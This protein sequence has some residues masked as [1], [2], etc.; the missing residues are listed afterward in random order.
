[1]NMPAFMIVPSL[2]CQ[3]SCKY[4][5][6][7][8]EGAVMD[9]RTAR[10]SIKF[11][12]N[13]ASETGTQDI[14][15][16]FHGGEPLL[17]PIE[18]WNAFFT[19]AKIQLNSYR[20]K[21]S[22]QSNLWRL[23]EEFIEL[24]KEN[25]VSIGTSLDGPKNLCDIN[26]GC[27]YYE[28][29]QASV[30]KANEAG[31]SVS[32]IA[33]ITKSTLSHAVEIAEYFRN[34][35]MPLALHGALAGMNEKDS[36]FALSPEEYSKMIL[37]LFPWYIENRKFMQI[38]TLDHFARAIARGDPG[39]CTFRDCFGMFACIS[40]DGGITSCQRLSGKPEFFMGSIFD[41]PSLAQLYESGPAKAQR[42]RE[43]AA[44]IKCSGCLFYQ[45]CKGGCYYNAVSSGDGVIDPLCEAYKDIFAFVQGK[46]MEEMRSEE[47]IQAVAEGIAGTY[48]HPLLRKGA[49]ISLS[50]KAH[51]ARIADN[52]RRILAVY[53]LGKT[54][55]AHEAALNLFSQRICG[56]IPV[57]EKLLRGIHQRLI[58]PG[59]RLN[60]CYVHVTLNCNLRCKHCYADAGTSEGQMDA[61]DFYRLAAEAEEAKF[62]QIVITGGE[63]LVHSQRDELIEI[64][65]MHKGKGTNLVLRTNLTG[66]LPDGAFA[67]LAAAFDQVVVSVDGSEEAHDLRRGQGAYE[68]MARNLEKYARA[69]SA[70]PKSAE[71]S[72]ACVTSASD[73]NGEQGRSVQL[74][75]ESLGVKRVRFRPLLP[76]GRAAHLE[77][78]AMCEGLLQHIS[79]DDML[80]SDFHPLATCGIGQNLFIKPDGSAHPC[81]AWCG[82]HTYMGNAFELGIGGVVSSE[83]FG[84]L[85]GCT[86]DTINKCRECGYRYLCGGACRAWGNQ[87]ELD[88]NAA[89]PECAHLQRRAQ[90]LVDAAK[91]YLGSPNV[92]FEKSQKI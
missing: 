88:L 8:H 47:N 55:D 23:N 38:D 24:F 35:G 18:I 2:A 71:L 89:P 75:G 57:T 54:G 16:I 20:V 32:A 70:I 49:Y 29:T 42:S 59:K 84:R 44:S 69:A 43:E 87:D 25:R 7:P 58:K 73:A 78:P 10:E 68:S 45:I 81:Y 22:L 26:R 15:I 80:K 13:I 61:A 11:I 60:N 30:Q 62:R 9:E 92:H 91:N 65:K 48:E 67:D 77:E 46:V 27:G 14:T 90:E 6:G 50:N 3:A 4:C 51:P 1:M 37:N 5:F 52:A 53:E 56:S 28:K 40:P 63:P 33:T 66:D 39:V 17:A 83:N 21:F 34:R 86:V 82:K 79:A 72:L 85:A 31:C 76:L 64:C 19:E 12:R 41:M 74:L 36:P